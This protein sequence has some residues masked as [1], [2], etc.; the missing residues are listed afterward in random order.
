VPQIS[1]AIIKE[2]DRGA[3]ILK[4]Q[5]AYTGQDKDVLYVVVSR[6]QL[7]RLKNIVQEADPRAFV[8]VNDVREV[9]G[10]GFRRPG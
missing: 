10:E 5:G 4:G 8:I 1:Q 7:L 9:L 2:L 6:Y 3:T